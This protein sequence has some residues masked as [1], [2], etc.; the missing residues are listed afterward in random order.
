MLL[1]G[2]NVPTYLYQ[3]NK[4]KHEFEVSHKMSDV[5]KGKCPSCKHKKLHRLISNSSGFVLRGDGWGKDG[6]CKTQSKI[7]KIKEKL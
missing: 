1:F 4:C 7:N 5:F 3:C 6:Y 2:G